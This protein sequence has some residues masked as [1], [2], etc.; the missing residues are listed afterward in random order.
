MLGSIDNIQIAQIQ[1]F[2]RL[3]VVEDISDWRFLQV[4]GKKVLDEATWQKVEKR[5]AI[6]PANGNPYKQNM[7]RLKN[8]L[9]S[10]FSLTGH[11]LK[12]Y[13]LCDWDY[14]PER[15]EL[16]R[17]KNEEDIDF[18]IWKRAEIENY[19]LVPQAI[20]RLV[21]N[22]LPSKTLFQDSLETEFFKLLDQS[23]DKVEEKFISGKN[24][25]Y[26]IIGT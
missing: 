25:I 11:P 6:F 8:Q 9:I 4:F 2:K 19:L 14:Y 26:L 7:V 22:K 18:Y 23:K 10:M 1:N 16:L 13:V 3:L 24:G 21:E 17:E 12:M 20:L 5:L 15:E